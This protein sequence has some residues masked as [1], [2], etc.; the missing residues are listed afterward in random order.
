MAKN[1]AE[2]LFKTPATFVRGV[3]TYDQLPS[4]NLPEVAFAGRSNVGKSSLINAITNNK[5]LARASTTPGRTQQL[6]YFAI[7]K[8]AFLV[9]LPGYGFAQA[10]KKT[11]EAWTQLVFTFLKERAQLKRVFVLIDSRH[12][13]KKVDAQMMDM[14]DKAGVSYQLILTKQ[15]KITPSFAGQI[16]SQTQQI[17]K[18]HTAC[19]PEVLITSAEKKEGISDV[20]SAFYKAIKNL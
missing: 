5:N 11:V 16:L 18:T 1:P 13:I 3:M 8:D 9:D 17:A 14:L 6:N 2:D 4:G 10:P 19:Y 12:G 15:D 7:G 20:R